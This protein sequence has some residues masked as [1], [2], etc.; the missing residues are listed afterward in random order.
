MGLVGVVGTVVG[1]GLP[2]PNGE[3]AKSEAIF[4]C[5]CESGAKSGDSD[6]GPESDATAW[7][8]LSSDESVAIPNALHF[9]ESNAAESDDGDAGHH[10]DACLE[11]YKPLPTAQ[12]LGSSN[13]GL[14]FFHIDVESV[15][16][17]KWL[18]YANVGVV[19]VLKGEVNVLE[20]EQNFTEMWKTKWYWQIRQVG[21]KKFLIRLPPNKNINELVEYPSI[22]INKEGVSVCFTMWNG[23]LDPFGELQ[24][25]WVKVQGIPPKWCTWKVIAQVASSLRVL[26]NVDWHMIFRSFYKTVRMKVF[27]REVEKIPADRIFEMEKNMYL[28]FFDVEEEEYLD[29]TDVGDGGGGDDDGPAGPDDDDLGD[30]FSDHL[31]DRNKNKQPMDTDTHTSLY[32]GS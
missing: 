28:V 21:A 26:V 29:E 2:L 32:P 22:N 14:G 13:A 30:D 27:V 4:V 24:E 5:W 18:N 16:A 20:L 6:A 7:D 11:W 1:Q 3:A 31:D 25:V 8:V 23:E 10:M 9:S 15:D 19:E 12:Y 17:T